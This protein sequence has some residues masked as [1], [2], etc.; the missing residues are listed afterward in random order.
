MGTLTRAQMNSEVATI[1]DRTDLTSEINTRLQWALDAVA[2]RFP[3]KVLEA[4]DTSL[5][6][7]DGTKSY[8]IPSSLRQVRS[9]RYIN[10]TDSKLLLYQDVDD[11]DEQHPYPEGDD[12]GVPE[13]WTR[14]GSKIELYPIPGSD[15]DGN[16]LYLTGTKWPTAFSGDS[17]TS[18]LERTLDAAIVYEAAAMCFELL[19]EVED[20]AY[21]HRQADRVIDEA[22]DAEERFRNLYLGMIPE[23]L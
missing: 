3:W 22:K 17:D 21:W 20:A 7:A 5:S 10:G 4:T 2:G 12:E 6:C 8:T 19:Q 16:S 11:F 18:D 1:I 14:R 15:E 23:D 13:M 9:V